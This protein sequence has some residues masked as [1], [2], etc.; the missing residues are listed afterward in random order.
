MEKI[1]AINTEKYVMTIETSFDEKYEVAEDGK[2]VG[3]L[4]SKVQVIEKQR[5]ED[6]G[7]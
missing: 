6:I 4:R 3:Y 2:I 7:R 1:F 5:V